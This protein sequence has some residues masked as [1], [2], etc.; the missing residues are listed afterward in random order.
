MKDPTIVRAYDKAAPGPGT[1]VRIFE[2]ILSE[3][4]RTPQPRGTGSHPLLR[5]GLL[6][7]ACVALLAGLLTAGYAA[8]EK[9]SLPDPKPIQPDPKNGYVHVQQENTYP[10]P[11]QTEAGTT[12]PASNSAGGE[13]EGLSDLDF[14]RMA[15]DLLEQVGLEAPEA[16]AFRVRRQK[17]LLWDREETEVRLE[18]GEDSPYTVT[19]DSQDG[20]LLGMS[21]IDWVITDA[22]ACET[23]QEADELA[24]RYYESLPV[25]QGYVRM[26]PEEYDEQYWSYDFCRE[27][28]PGLYSRYECVRV[29]VNPVSGKLVGCRVFYVPLLDDHQPEDIPLTQEEAEAVVKDRMKLDGFTL[30]SAKKTVGLPNWIFSDKNRYPNQKASDVTRLCWE[31][32][33]EKEYEMFTTRTEILVDY[34]TGEILG[35]DTTG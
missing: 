7:A 14:I 35:G 21:G 8:Y 18:R 30:V 10:F 23:R 1:E 16:G 32:V 25:P 4:S 9:W 5:R 19:F 11:M 28:E 13:A 12:L 6:A 17:N 34:Y 20:V 31:L 3:A 2:R 24:R 33:Y 26:E 27:V 15:R 22:A 29:S